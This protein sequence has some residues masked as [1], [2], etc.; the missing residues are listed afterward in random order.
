MSARTAVKHKPTELR[1]EGT[2][3]G[4]AVF[5]SASRDGSYRN[6]TYVDVATLA[7]SCECKA[8][9]GTCW[10]GDHAPVAFAMTRV[11]AYLATLDD[12]TLEVVG[13][14]AGATIERR[15]QAI[16]DL[17]VYW[18]AKREW[19]GRQRARREVAALLAQL[20][21]P[22]LV[23][24]KR[25]GG[26]CADCGQWTNNPYLCTDCTNDVMAVRVR[27]QRAEIAA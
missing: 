3:N 4:V 10:H 13:R 5:S 11:A 12:A 19:C 15:G 8:P 6:W 14:A 23:L 22:G 17:A 27:A 2:A 21:D 24:A 25:R 18:G 26:H 16:T 1:H 20:P 9:K 7:V